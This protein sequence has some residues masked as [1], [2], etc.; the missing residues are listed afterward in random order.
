MS[1]PSQAVCGFLLLVLLSGLLLAAAGPTLPALPAPVSNNAV[2]TVKT[3]GRLLLF[4]FMGIGSK[5]SWDAVTNTGYYL[6]PD[7]DKWYPTKP[8]PGPAGRL[9]A[10]AAGVRETVFLFGG[11]VVDPQNHGMVVPDVNA[12]L[13]VTG[14]WFRGADLPVPVADS[15]IGVYRDRYIYLIGGRSNPGIVPNVQVYDAAKGT[16]SQGTPIP[17][18]P[19]FGHAGGVLDDTIVYVDG[20]YKN[21]AAGSPTYLA[22]DQCW[23]GKIDHHDPA[24]IEWSKLP[25]H[26]GAAR[27]GIAAGASEKDRKIYFSGGTDNPAGYNGLG[28]D[29]KPSEPS[30]LTFAFNLRTGKWEVVDENTPNPTMNSRGLLITDKGLAIVGGLTKGQQTTSQVTVLPDRPKAR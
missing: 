14:H 23:M 4:S 26:P 7:W 1:K 25:I 20:A 27:F 24:K 15:V 6:D 13:T 21:T 19:V 17:G 9:A 2:A 5:K 18:T 29:G 11:Y 30:S 3:R 16:W 12:Y 28:F 22:S 10:S 8:V